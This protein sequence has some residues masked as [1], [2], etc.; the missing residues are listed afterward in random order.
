MVLVFLTRLPSCTAFHTY[1]GLLAPSPPL[2][3]PLTLWLHSYFIS[4]KDKQAT[5][6]GEQQR[7][8]VWFLAF[9]VAGLFGLG[10]KLSPPRK[11]RQQAVQPKASPPL[12]AKPSV[13]VSSSAPLAPMS[14]QDEEEHLLGSLLMDA[15]GAESGD[16][17]D[18][19][20]AAGGG[21]GV[22]SDEE[23]TMAVF[24]TVSD[25]DW[26]VYEAVWGST[27]LHV[28]ITALFAEYALV[29]GRITGHLHYNCAQPMSDETAE[30]LGEL[31]RNFVLCYVNPI[32]GAIASTKIHKLLCHIV[33]AIKL[34]GAL[35]NGNTGRNESLHVHEKQRYCRTNGDPDARGYQLLRAGQGT[36]ELRAKHAMEE[37][38][39][40]LD[41]EGEQWE[42]DIDSGEEEHHDDV[43][44]LGA[45]SMQA[46]LRRPTRVTVQSVSEL[47]ARFGLASLALTLQAAPCETV[48][49]TGSLP[50]RAR[51]ECCSSTAKQSV[52]ATPFFR[53]APWFDHVAFDD[54][55]KPGGLLYGKARAIVHSVGGREER[56]VVV[57]VLTPCE[58]EPGCPLVARGCTRLCWD[59]G[60][61]DEWPSLRAVPFSSVRRLLHVVPDMD[62]VALHHGVDAKPAPFER[63]AADRRDARFFVNAFYPWL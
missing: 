46:G 51:F 13:P 24:K 26:V 7:A 57:S 61:A 43:D 42:V 40:W 6:T 29:V 50:I 23:D 25:F 62:W 60:A 21:K 28:A 3:P 63:S 11:K 19:D 58:S 37:N 16:E 2:T 15:L 5:F 56:V 27:P 44:A 47:S 22:E 59:M 52:R 20:G 35:S 38:Q 53:G 48:R 9:F 31:C 49:L 12:S 32:L 36:L 41:E 1:L 14:P 39:E 55:D 34:H 4:P 18:I 8:G 45:A 33:A 30:E 54:T 10:A 17:V